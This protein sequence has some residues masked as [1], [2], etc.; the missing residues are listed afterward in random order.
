MIAMAMFKNLKKALEA[1]DS[2]TSLRLNVQEHLPE[3]LTCFPNLQ[4]LYIQSKKMTSLPAW[5]QELKSLT[6]LNIQCP[7]LTEIPQEIFYLPNLNVLNLSGCGISSLNFPIEVL[8]PLVELNLGRNKLKKFPSN[9]QQC[10]T[11]K[12]LYLADN[13]IDSIPRSIVE[14]RGLKRLNLDRNNITNVPNYVSQMNIS[15]FSVDGNPFSK[16][17]KDRLQSEL[18]LWF[19]AS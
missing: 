8:S 5:A 19:Q 14:L 7:S 4:I 16:E 17:E 6:S 12:G 15:I 18:N 11:L 1:R 10:K 13:Q 9:I 3:E 2:V